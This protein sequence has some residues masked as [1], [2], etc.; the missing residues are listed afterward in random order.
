[1][2]LDTLAF[3]GGFQEPVFQAQAVFR[4]L[5]D[6]MAR[7]GTIGAIAATV[8]PPKPLTPA[9]GAIA[10]TLCDHDTTVWLTPALAASALPGW[11]AFNAGAVLADERQNARFAFI[12]K[13][14]MLPNFCLFAQGTQ[15][16]PDLSTTLVVEIEAFEGGRPLVLKGPGIRTQ[17]EI[18]PVGL[19][20]MFPQFWAENR[21]KFPRGV[22][23]ILVA[24]DKIICLPRTTVISVKEA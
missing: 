1:M 9:A 20:D 21:Q 14:A 16:Y 24:G 18:A 13:G 3:S 5:M 10:L 6:C 23:L 2:T 11:L 12:E 4:T 22:D 8:T 19:P 17:E 15:E 7:P